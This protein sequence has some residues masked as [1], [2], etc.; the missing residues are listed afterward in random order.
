MPFKCNEMGFYKNE[1][2]SRTFDYSTFNYDELPVSVHING[3]IRK[4]W[5]LNNLDNSLYTAGKYALPNGCFTIACISGKGAIIDLE[6]KLT[7]IP[8]GIYLVGLINKKLKVALEPYSKVIMAQ[9]TPWTASLITNLPLHE[10]RNTL[11]PL[12]LLNKSLFN[13]MN[14]VDLSNETSLKTILCKELENRLS[15][16]NDTAFVRMAF[17][18]FNKQLAGASLKIDSMAEQMR[19]SKR[20]LEQKFKQNIGL[21]PKEI[22]AILKMRALVNELDLPL[23]PLSL[24]DLAYK[25]GYADQ[26][27]FIKTY[28]KIMGDR[29]G[30]FDRTD[31][32]IPFDQ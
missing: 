5:I 4:F 14:R 2:L 15:S 18:L 9:L 21:A 1:M 6:G 19:C 22:Y 26:S 10:L 7:N 27:H 13:T 23:K 16:S 12:Q 20:L 3:Y 25:Y 30:V 24:T 28:Y 31:Y 29:P 11:V 32:I 17:T 8:P